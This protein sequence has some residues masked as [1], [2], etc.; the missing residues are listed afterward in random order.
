MSFNKYHDYQFLFLDKKKKKKHIRLKFKLSRAFARITDNF[1]CKFIT[2]NCQ[3]FHGKRRV[4][5]SRPHI[6]QKSERACP[7]QVL[8]EGNPQSIH[9][10][11]PHTQRERELH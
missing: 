8:Q 3:N 1:F 7:P 6:A 10:T 11:D 5:R 4:L 2:K 9:F